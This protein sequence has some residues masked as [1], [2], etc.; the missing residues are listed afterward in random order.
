MRG[1]GA[2]YAYER[3]TTDFGDARMLTDR[4]TLDCH[5]FVNTH[6][7]ALNHLAFNGTWYG[8]QR[9][10][11]E[12]GASLADLA[13]GIFTRAVHADIPA[14]RGAPFVTA[15]APVDGEDIEAAL[16]MAGVTFEP[17]DALLLDCGR[18]AFEAAVGAWGEQPQRPGA[19]V[20]AA[21]WLADNKASV[22]L[23][24]M[25]D[26]MTTAHVSGA[27]HQ[28]HWATGLILVD[29]CDFAQARPALLA[30]GR[31]SGAVAIAPLRLDGATGCN[32]NPMLLT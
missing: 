30:S 10:T 31:A 18:D 14:A 17:G 9:V 5:G 7:D 24:D 27:V 16:A 21:R 2:A 22:L 29:N 19:G 28:L 8:G 20:G 13:S 11:E 25:L 15:D 3:F 4:L 1:D 23:W 32:V 12:P 26:S 6:I